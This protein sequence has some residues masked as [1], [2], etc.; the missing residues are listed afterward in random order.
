MTLYDVTLN[1]Q[2]RDLNTLRAILKTAGDAIQQQ[3]SRWLGLL[4]SLLWCSRCT[5][6]YQSGSLDCLIT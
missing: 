6:G 2:T 3:N 1:G 4:D 5:V